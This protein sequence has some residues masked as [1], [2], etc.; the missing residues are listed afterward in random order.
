M[1][2]VNDDARQTPCVLEEADGLRVPPRS[3]LPMIQPAGNASRLA[4]ALSFG[5]LDDVALGVSTEFDQDAQTPTPAQ[6]AV[7]SVSDR[8]AFPRRTSGCIACVC[9]ISQADGGT[10]TLQEQEWQLHSSQLR[11]ELANISMNGVTFMLSESLPIDEVVALRLTNV[12]LDRSIDVNAQVLRVVPTDSGN[13]RITCR[14]C[15]NLTFK[16]INEFG[17]SLFQSDFV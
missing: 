9:R 17:R 5:T 3:L 13:W 14:F 8:R 15:E 7:R 4:A 6:H 1:E 11:G 2:T 12:I 10:V 16:Q